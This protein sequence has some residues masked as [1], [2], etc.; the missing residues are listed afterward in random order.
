MY[1]ILLASQSPRRRQLLT[2]AGI[3][4]DTKSLKLSELIDK[5]LN[6]RDAIIQLAKDKA[7]SAVRSIKNSEFRG[8]LL[9]TAD[10]VVVL[11]GEVLGKPKD[12]KEAQ[13]FLR[14]LSGRQHEV[15][16]GFCVYNFDT[17]EWV[18]G[19]E[20]TSVWFRTL[21]KHEISDYIQT[22]EPL[23]KAGAYAIQGQGKKFVE[24]YQG[25]LNN[26]IG[27]PVN[28]ILQTL[29]L[30]GWHVARINN[31]SP[32]SNDGSIR[33]RL[34]VIHRQIDAALSTGEDHQSRKVIVV[35]ASKGQS[36][37][38]IQ[39]AFE[40]GIIDFGENYQQEAEEKR[41]Q[42]SSLPQ[43]RWH[44]IGGL[45]SKKVK[46]VV[47]RFTLI[48]SVDRLSLIEEINKRCI[49]SGLKQKIL[50]QVNVGDEKSKSG[51]SP[52]Q[53]SELMEKVFA[54][55]HLTL[56]GLMTMPPITKNEAQAR[57][58][59]SQLRSLFEKMRDTYQAEL[60]AGGHTF[61]E[62]SMGTSADFVAALKEGATMIRL[63][64]SL[65]GERKK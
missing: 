18:E 40:S 9:L 62:L 24:R 50:L 11:D 13:R 49:I 48:H 17:G 16:T 38:Q 2:E 32:L 37:Q 45:Q 12:N 28:E 63:G 57:Q 60:V 4:F 1:R 5:N 36:T 53:L 29:Q 59:F 61:N 21:S 46:D 6:L 39:E 33:D 52:E 7:E 42:L 23:D 15:M 55:S 65:F 30:K 19:L 26:V 31:A 54:S 64:S 34:E 58:Y 44:F 51:C 41:Q 10:T 8:F 56:A 3:E 25:S 14:S 35:A 22:G 47:G 27:L 20:T 43:L